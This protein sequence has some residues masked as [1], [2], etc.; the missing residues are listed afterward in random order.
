MS[1]Y[2]NYNA[3]L[4]RKLA[5]S[6]ENFFD[7][8]D[9]YAALNDS[10]R[11]FT[12]EYKPEELRKKV[13]VSLAREGIV[14]HDCDAFNSSTYGTFAVVAGT[15]AS[16]VATDTTTKRFGDGS[17]SLTIDTS[18][19]VNDYAEFEVAAL[20]S[21]DLS[22]HE[23][24]GLFRMFVYLPVA[25]N[26]SNIRLDVG[27]SSSDYWSIAA[28]TDI[29]GSNFSSGGWTRIEFNWANA[30]ENGTP[31]SS[32]VDYLKLRFTYAASFAGGSGFRIDDIRLVGVGVPPIEYNYLVGAIPSDLSTMT[33]VVRVEYPQTGRTFADID[34]ELYARTNGDI[35]TIDYNLTT[36]D[37]RI[38]VNDTAAAIPN[39]LLTYIKDPTTLVAASTESGLNS[40]SDYLIVL[41]AAKILLNDARDF[42]SALAVEKEER[43]AIRTWHQRYGSVTRRLKSRFERVPYHER[44]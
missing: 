29:N 2:S 7:E 30:T 44:H 32:N 1:T 37:R 13:T 42:E 36:L 43:E 5:T 40:K 39:V 10:I 28:T 14:L 21:V 26:L 16:A 24:T 8:E 19:S 41:K 20:T 38:H 35:W 18:A 23:D 17:V 12:D 3:A 6:S 25:T 22:S 9:R 11:E 34:P 15:D 31:D 27:S 33:R 4:S